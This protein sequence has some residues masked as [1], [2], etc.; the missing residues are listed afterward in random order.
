MVRLISD[1]HGNWQK[2]LSIIAGAEYS[3]QVGDLGFW[4]EYLEKVD[5]DKHICIPGNHDNYDEIKNYPHFLPTYG[6]RSHGGL[7]FFY[8]RGAFS[9]DW[10]LRIERELQGIWPK[11]YWEQEELSVIKLE[12]AVRV[13]EKTK[14]DIVITHAAPRSVVKYV[15]DGRVLKNFGFD[16]ETFTTRTEEA[17]DAMFEIHQPKLWVH[18]H[19]HRSVKFKVGKTQFQCLAELEFVDL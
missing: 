5:A 12:N 11:T 3:I 8:V 10:K 1:I 19:Y 2:Y 14:P 9:I 4:Y 16:P 17:L 7:D 6:K 15:T 18:G 13:Y